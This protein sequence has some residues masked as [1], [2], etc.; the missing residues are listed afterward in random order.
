LECQI[1]AIRL[2]IVF[3]RLD[4]D[5]AGKMVLLREL[6]LQPGPGESHVSQGVRLALFQPR[7]AETRVKRMQTAL[8]LCRLLGSRTD[9]LQ[10]SVFCA[11]PRLDVEID[12]R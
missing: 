5:G 3:R 11:R 10:V 8:Q 6:P 12:V 2:R 1:G 4:V 7:A 9:D